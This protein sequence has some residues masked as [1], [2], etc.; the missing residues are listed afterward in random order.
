MG[1][2]SAAS[3]DELIALLQ[4][5]LAEAG[6]DGDQLIAIGTHRRRQTSPLLLPLALHSAVPLRL[7]DEDDL[8]GAGP[9]LA[10]A[11][12]SLAGPLHLSRRQSAFATCAL[13][14]CAPGFSLDAFGQPF[15]SSAVMAS[16]A[17]LTSIAG[18]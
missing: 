2:A 5:C 9:G 16:S 15:S 17:L 7:F 10:E 1:F 8:C 3:A 11:V 18:P 13:A 6:L 4:A 14:R 12:A